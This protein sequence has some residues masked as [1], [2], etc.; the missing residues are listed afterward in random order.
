MNDKMRPLQPIKIERVRLDP[1]RFLSSGMPA[2][3]DRHAVPDFRFLDGLNDRSRFTR[4][5]SRKSETDSRYNSSEPFPMYQCVALCSC[6]VKSSA[7]GREKVSIRQEVSGYVFSFPSSLYTSA[8]GTRCWQTRD[9]TSLSTIL[10]RLAPEEELQPALDAFTQLD[11][12][13]GALSAAATSDA[14]Y[15]AYI[16]C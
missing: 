14:P 8:W 1:P 6:A 3:T 9:M 15:P 7:F 2:V 16:A 12:I 4:T 11:I 10:P 13:T 5:R